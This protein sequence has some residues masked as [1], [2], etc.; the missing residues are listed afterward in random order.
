[1]NGCLKGM[2]H[3]AENFYGYAFHVICRKTAAPSTAGSRFSNRP[4]NCQ[5]LGFSQISVKG[6]LFPE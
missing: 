3:A 2:G 4:T 5:V 6:F 1:M